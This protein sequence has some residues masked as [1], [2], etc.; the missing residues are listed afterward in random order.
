MATL[1]PHCNGEL[2]H[3]ESEGT[4]DPSETSDQASALGA[5]AA[6]SGSDGQQR[7]VSKVERLTGYSE[8]QMEAYVDPPVDPRAARLL[9]LGHHEASPCTR[10][11]YS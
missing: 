10:N 8:A 7:G 1:V 4:C 3:T 5:L 6:S 11:A 9:H 2:R